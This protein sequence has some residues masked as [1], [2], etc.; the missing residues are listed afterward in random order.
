MY[1]KYIGCQALDVCEVKN[2]NFDAIVN[3]SV[4]EIVNI[5]GSIWE[6]KKISKLQHTSRIWQL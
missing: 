4:K 6:R 1:G 3:T 5:L 2:S